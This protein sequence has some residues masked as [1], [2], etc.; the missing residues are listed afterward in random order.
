MYMLTSVDCKTKLISLVTGVAVG[1]EPT[2]FGTGAQSD[3]KASSGPRSSAG[4]ERR[5]LVFLYL[6]Y[7]A[8]LQTMLISSQT[9]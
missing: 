5:Q 9:I 1:I 2:T 7:S 8:N 3:P 6:F 4:G